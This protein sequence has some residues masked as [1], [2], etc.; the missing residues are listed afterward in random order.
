MIERLFSI[1]SLV[2]IQRALVCGLLLS[3]CA[4]LLGVILVQKRYSLIGHGLSDVSF[5]SVA[6][7][8]ALGVSPYYVSVPIVII[9]AVVIMFIGQKK[10]EH[11]DVVIG[12]MATGA[13]AAGVIITALSNGFN[14]D[15]YGYMFGSI[16]AVTGQDLLLAAGLTALVGGTFLLLYNRLLAVTYDEGYAGASGLSAP[17]YQL[18]ISVLTALTV[19]FSMKIM[20]TLLISSL[21][22]FPC[23]TA[24]KNARSFSG[25][26]LGASVVSVVCFLLGFGASALLD[27]PTGASIVAANAAAWLLLTL[28]QKVRLAAGKR[29]SG[30]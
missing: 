20:G 25:L 18:I 17:M 1:L 3:F 19:V 12:M 21:I 28:V 16:V 29:N 7:A 23:V 6:L 13:L 4:A 15:V 10:G 14:T 30:R 9:A 26:L 27:L 2:S 11:G 22:I 8:L 24:R 5:A